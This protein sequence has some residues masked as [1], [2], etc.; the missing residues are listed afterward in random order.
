VRHFE[1]ITELPS[2]VRALLDEHFTLPRLELVAD[3]RSRDG[4]R[5][6]LFRLA[7]GQAIETV[8]IPDAGRPDLLH[9]V[10]GRVRAP[11]LVLRHRR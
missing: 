6:F 1:E 7:D 2:A 4:T 5:K 9:L 3:Q 11:V 8:A 10:A